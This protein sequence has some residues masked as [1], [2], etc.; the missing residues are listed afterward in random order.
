MLNTEMT[1]FLP[2]MRTLLP[3]E[4]GSWFMLGFP[5]T[6]ALLLRPSLAGLCLGLAALAF[7]FARP[8]LRRVFQGRK[9]AN[10]I[11]ALLLFS[12]L[13]AGFGSAA[14]AL[15]G[16]RFLIPLACLVPLAILALRA[17]LLRTARSL[18]VELA[19]QGAF[20]GLAATMLMAGGEGLAGACRAWLLA[21]L[22]G[23]ANLAHVRRLLGCAHHLDSRETR[24]RSLAVHLIHLLLLA[25]SLGLLAS[26]G[27]AGRIWLGWA[28]L[29]YL[30]ALAPYRPVPAR[31]LGWRE[32]GLSVI[33]LLAL[34][35]AL[36]TSLPPSQLR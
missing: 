20:A 22:V 18:V 5:L 10:Q 34:A 17:D 11:R 23:G 32:G 25:A 27:L 31:T 14:L 9:D 7:F 36:A 24:L 12:G 15:S 16:P 33:T 13:A 2:P 1:S 19:A 6:L 35:W 26:K 30:R 8:A 21:A 28:F 4:H 3:A 29:L